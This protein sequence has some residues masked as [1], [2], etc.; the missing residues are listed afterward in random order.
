MKEKIKKFK[1]KNAI[2]LKRLMDQPLSL[3]ERIY[4]FFRKIK[5]VFYKDLK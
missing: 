3:K 4:V 5:K 1:I 2:M